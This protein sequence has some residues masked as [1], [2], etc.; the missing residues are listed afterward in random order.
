MSIA[1]PYIAAD[2]DL[3][4]VAMGVVM[5]IFFASY[6]ISQIPGG[7]LA[8]RFGVRRVA[9]IALLWWSMF[10]AI[11]A[12]AGNLSQMLFARLFFGFGE[13]V[14]PTCAFKT[15]AVW[16]PKSER[17]TANAIM[18]AAGS[19]GAML[20][21][22]IVVPIIAHWGWRAAFY[23]LA[24]PGVIVGI[25]FWKVVRDKPQ[26]KG[27]VPGETDGTASEKTRNDSEEPAVKIRFADIV[28][29]PNIV[30]YILIYF[31]FDI[32]YWGL[33]SWLPTYLVRE[34]GFS[35]VEMG[36]TAALPTS[37]R[38]DRFRS[39]GVALGSI[40]Q[41]QSQGTNY[42]VAIIVRPASLSHFHNDISVTCDFVS[43]CR[44]LHTQLLFYR[45]LGCTHEHGAG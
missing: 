25:L 15:V 21:P 27:V 28:S 34:R 6:A 11:T 5:S 29:Q 32:A 36:V 10:T 7:L 44:R 9:T 20:A 31:F 13:G 16:F 35:L 1:I 41:R 4:P 42:S 37:C 38:R 23:T 26:G 43:S 17:G 40:L 19:I 8:D 33:T 12:A 24:L 3:S 39:R 22:L 14:F 45:V 18:L 2:F 30:R